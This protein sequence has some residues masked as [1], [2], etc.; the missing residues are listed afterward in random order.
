MKKAVLAIFSLS[1]LFFAC[2]DKV[3]PTPTVG[4]YMSLT[5]GSKWTYDVITNPGMAGSTTVIDTVTSTSTDTMIN[6]RSYHI[7]KHT[8][9][10]VSDYFY[11]SGNDYYRF[12]NIVGAGTKIENIYL[13]SFEAAGS[14]WAQ[15]VNA[16]ISGTTLPITVTNSIAARGTTKTVNGMV[17]TDVIDVQ[18]VLSSTGLPAGSIV[19]D[20]HSYYAPKVG[21]IQGDYK[22]VVALAGIN[23]NTQT[24]IKT[25]VIL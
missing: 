14:S 9:G 24:L 3:V 17:Y 6:A 13:K 11:I 12:Q 2:K 4:S 20:I 16:S 15:T 10:S 18:T 23:I 7:V 19:S 22:V 8:N 5:A 21:L 25:A 1:F